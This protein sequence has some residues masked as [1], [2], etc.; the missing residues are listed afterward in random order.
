MEILS[1]SCENWRIWELSIIYLLFVE[2][3]VFI[4]QHFSLEIYHNI[5]K[6]MVFSVKNSLNLIIFQKLQIIFSLHK[7]TWIWIIK[8]LK[9]RKRLKIA[10]AQFHFSHDILCQLSADEIAYVCQTKII[11]L[12]K[13]F[14]F[15]PLKTPLKLNFHTI[16][17]KIY[18]I[19]Q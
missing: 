9:L 6:K 14:Q 3:K 5:C 8:G 15:Q 10:F 13:F 11:I 16:H 2:N 7:N 17:N 1:A 19:L 18:V 4:F 12:I